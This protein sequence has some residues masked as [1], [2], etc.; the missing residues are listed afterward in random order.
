M[1]SITLCNGK[2]LTQDGIRELD[3]AIE[4]GK[5]VNIGRD[6]KFGERI[7]CSGLFVLPGFRDQHIHDLPGLL[8]KPDTERIKKIAASLVKHGVT[9]AKLATIAMPLNKMLEYAETV[10]QYV[11]SKSNGFDGARIEGLHIEGTFIRR[12]CA[13]AQPREYI[14]EPWMPESK[15]ILDSLAKTGIAKMV[16][17]AADFGPDLIKY[18]FSKGF[19]VGCGH[20]KASAKQMEEAWKNGL[21]YIVHITNGAMG[22]SFKPFDGGGTYE[23]ALTLPLSVEIIVDGYHVDMRYVSDI[24]ERRIQKGREHEIIAV[25]DSSFAIDEEAPKDEFQVFSVVGYRD[26]DALF[27][28]R[29]IDESG[30]WREPPPN[31]LFGSLLTMDK[32]FENLLNMFSVDHEG[33]M[34]DAKAK[35]F[36]E[37][38][39]LSS[40]ITSRNQALLEGLTNVGAI[41]KNSIADIVVLKIDGIPGKYRVKVVKTIVNGVLHDFS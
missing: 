32:A 9:S 39:R 15:D 1:S 13:G 19:I 10:K 40:I 24:I 28:K 35:S 6:L 11:N 30:E 21:K 36:S 34:I 31:T 27:V 22:Q 33:F 23:A 29:F 14:M 12:E 38:V 5:I 8:S 18:A 37:A 7:D 41:K 2:V 26:G 20:S 25:T 3:V 16:N 17:I 4:E